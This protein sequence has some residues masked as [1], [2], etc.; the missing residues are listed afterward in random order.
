MENV[1]K[2][3]EQVNFF[4]MIQNTLPSNHVLVD[5]ISELLNIG[6]D[7]S[8]RRIRGT[9]LIDFEETI[10]LCKHFGISMSVLTGIS[11][12]NQIQCKY[13]PLDMQ[14]LSKYMNYIQVLSENIEYISTISKSEILLSASDIPIF[15]FLAYKELTFFK[16]F[17]WHKN[18]YDLSCNYDEFIKKIDT[19]ALLK[20]FNKIVR[21]YQSIPSSEIWSD[22]TINTVVK[23]IKYHYDIGDFKDR[24][25]PILLLEQL[26]NLIDTL[27]DWTEKGIK[28]NKETPFKLYISDT[29]IE[30]T[31]ILIKQKE[32]SNCIVKLFTINSLNISDERFCIETEKW[33]S[34]LAQ[35]STLISGA[36]AKERFKFFVNQKQKI[37]LIIENF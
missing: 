2:N 14:D 21:N 30:N 8:Y 13:T 35:R 5:V 11:D 24:T 28:G 6:I 3:K 29:D 37:R 25:I 15:N 34:N 31:F 4:K 20:C 18:S 32:K 7:S 23:M 19:E 36:S 33:L 9:K 27:Q 17:S 12:D 26:M 22:I 16:L 1:L 10:K